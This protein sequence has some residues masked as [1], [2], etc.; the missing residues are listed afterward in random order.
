[1]SKKRFNHDGHEGHDESIVTDNPT[2]ATC[3]FS[4]RLKG[5]CPAKQAVV[6]FVSVVVK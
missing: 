2:Y 1:M 3:S 6:L 4:K 5:L